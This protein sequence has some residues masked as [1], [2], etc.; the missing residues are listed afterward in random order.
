MEVLIA[1][2][3]EEVFKE[4]LPKVKFI[5][6]TKNTSFFVCTQKTFLKIREEI[7]NRGYN[8]YAIMAW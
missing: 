4:I 5:E 8:P 6:S 7:R 2:I 1:K 3:N